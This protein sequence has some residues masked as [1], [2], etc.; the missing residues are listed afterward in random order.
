MG[1]THLDRAA[2]P[3]RHLGAPVDLHVEHGDEHDG[4]QHVGHGD[5]LHGD[6]ATNGFRNDALARSDFEAKRGLALENCRRDLGPDRIEPDLRET[7]RVR[8]YWEEFAPKYDD[9]IAFYERVLF[10]GGREW[11]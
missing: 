6:D 8:R 5:R 2:H 1:Q 3:R 11:I 10:A 9:D 4:R 7:E